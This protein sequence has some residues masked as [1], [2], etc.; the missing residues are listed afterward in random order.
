MTKLRVQSPRK[1]E[2]IDGWRPGSTIVPG[3]DRQIH[4]AQPPDY[5]LI[6]PRPR[7]PAEGAAG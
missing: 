4:F 6:Q 1:V 7:Q 2:E 3:P 5:L